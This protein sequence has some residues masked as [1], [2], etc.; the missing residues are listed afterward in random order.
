MMNEWSDGTY[1]HMIDV[2]V[3]YCGSCFGIDFFFIGFGISIRFG[4]PK[5]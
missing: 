5:F 4:N 2:A 1:L 3:H